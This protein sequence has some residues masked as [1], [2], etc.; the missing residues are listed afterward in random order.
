VNYFVLKAEVAGGYGP[1][2]IFTDRKARPPILKRFNFEL[3]GWLGDPVL[4]TVSN[5]VV[6]ERIRDR[7]QAMGATGATFGEVEIS[8]SGEYDDWQTLHPGRELPP[9][10]W[11]QVKGVAGVDDFGYTIS[12]GTCLAV[13]ERVLDIFIECGMKNAKMVEL[14]NWKGRTA[15]NLRRTK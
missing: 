6:T 13:S 8:T 11:L 2:T 9:F 1:N 3:N 15:D 14:E 7:L 5:Y 10:V 12:N 4:M